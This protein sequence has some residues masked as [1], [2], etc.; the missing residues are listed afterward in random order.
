[1]RQDNRWLDE[2]IRRGVTAWTPEIPHEVDKKTAA[3]RLADLDSPDKRPVKFSWMKAAAV[4]AVLIPSVLILR[5]LWHRNPQRL[6][7]Q[8]PLPAAPIVYPAPPALDI[9]VNEAPARRK[10]A[11][12]RVQTAAAESANKPRQIDLLLTIADKNITIVWCQREDFNLLT[13]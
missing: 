4:A 11:R 7:C 13:E 1:M 12:R 5:P 9:V 3:C 10:A 8:A 6:V 2:R